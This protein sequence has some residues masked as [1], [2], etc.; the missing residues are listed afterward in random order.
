MPIISFGHPRFTSNLIFQGKRSL[1]TIEAYFVPL[2][3]SPLSDR[4]ETQHPG[5]QRH[6]RLQANLGELNQATTPPLGPESLW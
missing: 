4:L 6:S 5:Q 2:G 1:Q 3:S